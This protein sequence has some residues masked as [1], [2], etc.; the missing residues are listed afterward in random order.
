MFLLAYK[1]NCVFLD[2]MFTAMPEAEL[3]ELFDELDIARRSASDMAAGPVMR[4][5]QENPTKRTLNDRPLSDSGVAPIALLYDGFGIFDDILQQIPVP[6]EGAIL[7]SRLMEEVQKFCMA[8]SAF[9]PD[10]A[11]R[12]SMVIP[13]LEAIF[14]ARTDSQTMEPIQALVPG[15]DPLKTDGS[16]VGRH[17]AIAFIVECKNELVQISSE[18]HTELA[19]CITK[20]FREGSRHRSMLFNG[21]RV[22]A[23][24]MIQAGTCY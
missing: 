23:L 5:T 6:G 4:N 3:L 20:S 13:S 12:L 24:G 21:W 7:G 9:Y 14:D 10:E 2:V 15:D 22:P 17:G 8:M 16:M 18:P 1:L 11:A 19:N